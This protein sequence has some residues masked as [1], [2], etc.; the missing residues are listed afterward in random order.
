M[1]DNGYR[2]DVGYS[3]RQDR[4]SIFSYTRDGPALTLDPVSSG[5]K[6]WKGFLVA[7]NEFCIQHNGKPLLNQ[8]GSTT[9]L[10]AKS[11]FKA[12]IGEFQDIRH[13]LDSRDRFYIPYFRSL[14]E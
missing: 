6:G 5:S 3:I 7:Y 11:A 4:R 13:K 12:E 8:T 1:K 14:F 10:Q 9:P 2:C